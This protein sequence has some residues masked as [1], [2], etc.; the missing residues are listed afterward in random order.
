MEL[1]LSA[2]MRLARGECQAARAAAAVVR[3]EANELARR[4]RDGELVPLDAV[5]SA[6]ARA[7]AADARYAD[8][9]RL[10]EKR[11]ADFAPKFLERQGPASA[12]F[13]GGLADVAEHLDRV[14]A[15]ALAIESF[16]LAHSLP[17]TIAL[18]KTRRIASLARE[19]REMSQ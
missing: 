1:K 9:R 19:L 17:T 16:A 15:P 6:E 10:Y 8:T 11:R 12:A 14:L 4:H 13:C 3:G 2:G 18:S 7:D 5:H